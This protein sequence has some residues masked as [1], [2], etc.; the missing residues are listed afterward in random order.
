MKGTAG[1]LQDGIR[2]QSGIDN[3]ET[4]CMR[5]WKL[6]RGSKFDVHSRMIYFTKKW[7]ENG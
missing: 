7:M 2:I 3:V 5:N 1:V 4:W 6:F